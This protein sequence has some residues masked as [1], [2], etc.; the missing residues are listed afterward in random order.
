VAQTQGC[1]I[2]ACPVDG[3]ARSACRLLRAGFDLG[4]DYFRWTRVPSLRRCQA[5]CLAED[6]CAGLTW[7]Q[8]GR[9]NCALYDAAGAQTGTATRDQD[10]YICTP[11]PSGASSSS[12]SLPGSSSP[13]RPSGP[14]SS[15]SPR[16]A[17]T[18]WLL[19]GDGRLGRSVESIGAS[20]S[21]SLCGAELTGLPAPR[22]S[23]MG[24]VPSSQ[25]LPRSRGFLGGRV[26][27][28]GG[29]T[30][31]RGQPGVHT[32]C[33]AAAP[34]GGA[35]RRAASMPHNTSNAG[36]AVAGGNL[37]VA[38]GYTQPLCGYRPELQVRSRAGRACRHSS[39][40]VLPGHRLERAIG[41]RP[42]A[43]GQDTS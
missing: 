25:P 20:A 17:T 4:E 1:S 38:G 24:W 3:P 5:D 15:A 11:P 27:A 41:S 37:Y 22:A 23:M 2:Q 35:W 8:G 39:A 28:C 32:D 10:S 30:G 40:G 9:S 43:Q 19:G 18:S 12:S 31:G 26:L 13:S 21:G 42:A 16:G 14:P 34:S 29:S 33:W 36:H 7:V 6:R